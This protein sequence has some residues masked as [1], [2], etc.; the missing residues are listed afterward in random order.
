MS[1]LLKQCYVVNSGI[2]TRVIN[3]NERVRQK[4]SELEKTSAAEQGNAQGM[5]S[6]ENGFAE[7]IEAEKVKV[8]VEAIRKEVLDK[9]SAEADEITSAAKED[10]ERIRREAEEKADTLLNEQSRR[11]YEEGAKKREEELQKEHEKMLQSL[12]AEKQQLE[13]QYQEK[14]SNMEKDI[15]DAVIQVFDKVFKIQFEDKREI[16]LQLVNAT[17]MDIDPGDGIRIRTNRDDEAMLKEHL[18]QMQEIVGKDVTIEFVKDNKL[19]DGQ[20]KIETP[21]GVAD[22]GIDTQL[23]SLLKDIRSLV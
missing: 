6:G 9:A 21:Y 8:D 2:G 20:C 22:C 11:G 1:N 3:S 18:E 7:G 12:Q 19:S 17:L 10:A 14:R 15:V 13:E 5:E 4:L 23:S 16:L